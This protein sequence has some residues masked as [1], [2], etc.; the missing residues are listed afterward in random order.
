MKATETKFETLKDIRDFL[1]NQ[2]EEFLIKPPYILIGDNEQAD[3]INSAGV[4]DEHHINPSGECWEPI[5]VY[6]KSEDVD[7]REL[8]KTESVVGRKG[9]IFFVGGWAELAQMDKIDK[10]KT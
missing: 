9:D 8:A 3:R 2:P 6:S 10:S 5:S 4:L 1:N 7:D